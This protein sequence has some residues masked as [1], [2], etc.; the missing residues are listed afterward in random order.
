[1]ALADIHPFNG[2]G[3]TNIG[4]I[5]KRTYSSN[6]IYIIK[7]HCVVNQTSN[8]QLDCKQP[9]YPTWNHTPLE[10]SLVYVVYLKMYQLL[11]N[12]PILTGTS[13]G[14]LQLSLAERRWFQRFGRKA[15]PQHVSPRWSG[16]DHIW[17]NY[18][19]TK[20]VEFSFESTLHY[21]MYVHVYH[22]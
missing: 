7:T 2:N 16:Q 22:D 3:F 12:W 8:I 17:L 14:L 10:Q 1:M 6:Y 21:H 20:L 5:W 4:H 11:G 18:D 13:K 19:L 9:N 15:W